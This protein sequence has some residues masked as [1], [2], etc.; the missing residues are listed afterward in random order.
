MAEMIDAGKIDD[1]APG[2]IHRVQH[3][4]LVIALVNIAAGFLQGNVLGTLEEIQRAY[5]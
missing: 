5:R 2:K 3:G 1:L 4:D